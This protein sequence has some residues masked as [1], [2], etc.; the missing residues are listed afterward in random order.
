[1]N[2]DRFKMDIFGYRV[3][4]SID[5]LLR[6]GPHRRCFSDIPY[7]PTAGVDLRSHPGALQGT[8]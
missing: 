7:S 6:I 1:M 5:T 8:P 2:E 4:A 3:G